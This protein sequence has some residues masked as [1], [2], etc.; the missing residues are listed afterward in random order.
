MLLK[1]ALCFPDI[2]EENL[3]GVTTFTLFGWHCGHH[4]EQC[5]E[6]AEGLMQKHTDLMMIQALFPKKLS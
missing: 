5:S 1:H 4:V 2:F 6:W 3:S